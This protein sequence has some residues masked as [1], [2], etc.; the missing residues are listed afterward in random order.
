MSDPRAF[1]IGWP[2]DHSLS[3]HIHGH[4]LQQHDISGHYERVPVPPGEVPAFLA[5]ARTQGFVG[6][7]VTI[8]HKPAAFAQAGRTDETAAKLGVANTLVFEEQGIYAFNTD[9]YGF[10]ANLDQRAPGWSSG[11][12]NALA[13]VVGAGGAA[14]SVCFALAQRGYRLCIA[15]RTRERAEQ[16][17]A[18]LSLDAEIIPM[19]ALNQAMAPAS[20]VVNTT[21]LGM[22]GQPD[23]TVEF[24]ALQAPALITD[25]VYTPLLTPFL[26]RAQSAGLVTVDGLG[27]LLHQAVPGFAAWF[28]QR[29]DVTDQL[30]AEI[31][32]IVGGQDG[33]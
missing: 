10:L 12:G 19:A 22:V 16:L 28:G 18:D 23:L 4:W 25:I 9:P 6:G 2:I 26:Q 17:V 20:L 14:R 7:N 33:G 15:N 24:D 3:P 13:V 1:V 11:A 21:A 8:P 31:E 30:R 29:P 27:M 5:Q 32:A